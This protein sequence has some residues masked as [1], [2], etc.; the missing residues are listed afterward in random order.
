MPWWDCRRFARGTSSAVCRSRHVVTQLRCGIAVV[1]LRSGS[2]VGMFEFTAGCEELYDVQFLAGF[3]RPMILNLDRPAALQAVA[4]PECS[5]WLRPSAE[6]REGE[7][8]ASSVP[9]SAPP[10]LPG[11]GAPAAPARSV[12]RNS[13]RSRATCFRFPEL[14]L[15]GRSTCRV[16]ACPSC[17]VLL[18]WRIAFATRRVAAFARSPAAYRS[19]RWKNGRF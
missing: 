12:P 2:Q 1:D 18:L 15:R 9:M 13:K 6:I 11:G 14:R 8:N 4:H 5:W 7:G 19:T 17:A 3:S 16:S 10:L